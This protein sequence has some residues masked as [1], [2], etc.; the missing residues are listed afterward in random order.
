MKKIFGLLLMLTATGLSICYHKTYHDVS[1][2][3][4]VIAT[5][6]GILSFEGIR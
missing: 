4:Y 6:I 5:A 3:A 1:G 2:A